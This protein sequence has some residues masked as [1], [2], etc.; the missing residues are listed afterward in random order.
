MCKHYADHKAQAAEQAAKGYA[1]QKAVE[2]EQALA[3]HDA[4][5]S[6]HNLPS[7]A[8]M[9]STGFKVYDESWQSADTHGAVRAGR[10]R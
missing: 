5:S 3:D 10:I 8:K 4:N 9:E 7:Y 1:E 2:A 6:P